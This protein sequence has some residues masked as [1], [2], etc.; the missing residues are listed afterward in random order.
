M[1]KNR[2]FCIVVLEKT[3]EGPLDRKEIQ[4]VIYLGAPM[5]SACESEVAQLCPT[6]CDPM[7]TRLLCPWDFP[8]KN[9]AVGS[10]FLLQGIFPTHGIKPTSP[11]LAGGFFTTEP[12]GK[13]LTVAIC[14]K[15]GRAAMKRPKAIENQCPYG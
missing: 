5:L 3:L 6:L 2:C 14:Y 13:P 12:S 15:G 8:G 1:P 7:D 11:A 4:P 9:T 10:H